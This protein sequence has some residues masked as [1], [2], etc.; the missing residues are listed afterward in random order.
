MATVIWK[1]TDG[2]NTK[3]VIWSGIPAIGNANNITT[4]YANLS[5]I[6]V[7]TWKLS[8]NTISG[9]D[10]QDITPSGATTNQINNNILVTN[11]ISEYGI[12]YKSVTVINKYSDKTVRLYSSYFPELAQSWVPVSGTI[13]NDMAVDVIFPD[14]DDSPRFLV[15]L[16]GTS[17]RVKIYLLGSGI[18][19]GSY[20]TN[21]TAMVS[22]ASVTDLEAVRLI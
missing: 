6:Y 19:T 7:G 4:L 12:S 20:D 16:S 10:P 9:G 15:G 14:V 22:G 18:G 8:R 2:W 17:S 13:I 21:W 11:Y 1:S 3:N 5:H